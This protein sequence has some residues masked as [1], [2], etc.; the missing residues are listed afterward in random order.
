MS[1]L[2]VSLDRSNLNTQTHVSPTTSKSTGGASPACRSSGGQSCARR[3]ATVTI[4]QNGRRRGNDC[5]RCPCLA[6]PRCDVRKWASSF[7]HDRGDARSGGHQPSRQRAHDEDVT[8]IKRHGDLIVSSDPSPAPRDTGTYGVSED[9]ASHR[10]SSSFLKDGTTVRTA[11]RPVVRGMLTSQI[12]R[13]YTAPRKGLPYVWSSGARW[14]GRCR[15][16]SG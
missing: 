13:R 11:W 2:A 5:C 10:R 7:G 12:A 6:K 14:A 3:T 8:R 1:G 9:L 15:K 4:P 16:S